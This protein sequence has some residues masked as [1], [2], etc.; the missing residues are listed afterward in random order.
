MNDIQAKKQGEG[1]ESDRV[2]FLD[3][4]GCQGNPL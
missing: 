2:L 3:G 4:G 1:L